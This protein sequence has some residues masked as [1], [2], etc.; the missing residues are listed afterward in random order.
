MRTLNRILIALLAGAVL[1]VFVAWALAPSWGDL[2]G[3]EFRER[4]GRADYTSI[5]G[6]WLAAPPFVDSWQARIRRDDGLGPAN[7]DPVDWPVGII[8]AQ[9]LDTFGGSLIYVS[10]HRGMRSTASGEEPVEDVLPPWFD[11]PAPEP[12]GATMFHVSGWPMRSMRARVE[13]PSD[14]TAQVHWGWLV[15]RAPGTGVPAR[16]LPLRPIWLGFA[17]DT[18]FWG[19]VTGVFLGIGPCRRAMRRWRGRCAR[20]AYPLHDLVTCPECGTP[21]A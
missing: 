18:L 21:V 12:R 11:V 16:V 13:D 2:Y 15:H 8:F 20:C 9:R 1:T 17:V 7:G 14:R 5:N 6:S 10:R 19:A 4:R 3:R